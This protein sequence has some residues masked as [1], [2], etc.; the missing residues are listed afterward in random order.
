M[1]AFTFPTKRPSFPAAPPASPTT[2]IHHMEQNALKE[3]PLL[4]DNDEDDD[5]FPASP[6]SSKRLRRL[7]SAVASPVAVEAQ[8]QQ[9]QQPL[10]LA[11]IIPTRRSVAFSDQA[12][13]Q[14]P[15]DRTLEEVRG[16]W[17]SREEISTF[18]NDRKTA[19]K[20]LKSVEFRVELVDDSVCCLR[21]YE[22]YFSVEHN[23][24]TKCA[25]E[26]A[27]RAVLDEQE[28][29]RRS[30]DNWDGSLTTEAVRSRCLPT[31]EWA[32][33]NAAELGARDAEYARAVCYRE[34]NRSY[35]TAS[36]DPAGS[37]A[38]VLYWF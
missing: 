33:R 13:K 32:S 18:K 14:H 7:G 26:M 2:V 1:F 23:R 27:L 12:V 25:R 3:K 15:S 36:A 6:C 11:R 38:V 24:A 19:I 10:S 4:S 29:Q 35:N 20:V 8:Q 34:N 16:A 22:A 5:C 21:G 9:Q 31:S 30:I 28:R 37:D 17:Y